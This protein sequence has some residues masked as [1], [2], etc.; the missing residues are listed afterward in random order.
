MKN[1]KDFLTVFVFGAILLLFALPAAG[2]GIG[3]FWIAVDPAGNIVPGPI[4]GGTG[5]PDPIPE[6]PVFLGQWYT[7][8]QTDP[9][10]PW[11]N[12]WW[13]DD[14]YD[15]CHRKDVT[16][17]LWYMPLNPMM[18]GSIEVT[19]NWSLPGWSQ[20]PLQPPLPVD[21]LFVARYTPSW[22]IPVPPGVPVPINFFVGPI[23][24]P[25]DYNPEWVS[26]DVRGTNFWI[27]GIPNGY[28]SEIWHD[29]YEF[30]A[31]TQK[32][33]AVIKG[34]YKKF[35]STNYCQ[36]GKVNFDG[37]LSTD[38]CAILTYDWQLKARTNPLNSKS[39]TGKKPAITGLAKDTYDVTLTVTDTSAK[40]G[41]TTMVLKS[42][43][44]STA[45]YD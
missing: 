10:G 4:S 24:L 12:M 36:K 22:I 43:F 6:D 39:A 25:V 11:F 31:D 8:P 29:C 5:Y 35:A 7:Y 16:I 14:P 19:V 44:I 33:V 18:P 13:Y 38:D 9:A 17:N 45:I 20:N 26:I 1:A 37:S 23:H 30:T 21:E 3:Q 2:A 42:C 27:Q 34:D 15:A 40:T 41:S 28:Y 32:P